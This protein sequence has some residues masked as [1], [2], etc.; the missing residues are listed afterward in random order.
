MVQ[1]HLGDCAQAVASLYLCPA[2]TGGPDAHH[3]SSA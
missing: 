1:V 3:L 2:H